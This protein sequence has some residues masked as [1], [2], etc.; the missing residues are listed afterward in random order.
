MISQPRAHK[1]LPKHYR[2]YGGEQFAESIRLN[3]V[4]VAPRAE[5]RPYKNGINLLA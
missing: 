2:L 4:S 5:N 3:N 1:S